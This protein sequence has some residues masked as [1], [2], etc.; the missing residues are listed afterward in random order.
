M[1]KEATETRNNDAIDAARW[2]ALR[3]VAFISANTVD[4][5]V[6]LTAILSFEIDS[7]PGATPRERK[8]LW[9]EV[10]SDDDRH[11]THNTIRNGA[12]IDAL[13]DAARAE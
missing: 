13:W 4:E 10:T 7:L 1:N 5:C 11:G 12:R 2:R 3:D 9:G 6:F 8:I